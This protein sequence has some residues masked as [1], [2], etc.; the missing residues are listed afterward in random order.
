MLTCEPKPAASRSAYCTGYAPPR[1][2]FSSPRSGS[3]SLKLG[4]GG[5]RPVSRL[6][7]AT[8]SSMPVPIA[9]PVNPLVLAITIPSAAEPKTE[10]SEAISA[11]ALPPR[12]GV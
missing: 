12:A 4:M 8:T 2:R 7:T 6:L 5:T 11:D 9:W 3:V 1:E 10:R